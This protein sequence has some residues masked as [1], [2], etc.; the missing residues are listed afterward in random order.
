MANHYIVVGVDAGT[1]IVDAVES[2]NT[3]MSSYGRRMQWKCCDSSEA[4]RRYRALG[5]RAAIKLS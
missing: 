2:I 3:L 1:G 4:R 5:S